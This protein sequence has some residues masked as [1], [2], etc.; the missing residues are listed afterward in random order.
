VRPEFEKLGKN[1][2]GAVDLFIYALSGAH[3][4]GTIPLGIALKAH[5][6]VNFSGG[7]R[8]D[9]SG[10]WWFGFDCGHAGDFSPGLHALLKRM[11]IK[12]STTRA[13]A[14]HDKH[15][16]LGA[17]TP[18]G[19]PVTYRTVEYVKG[20]CTA[21]ALQLAELEKFVIAPPL[22]LVREKKP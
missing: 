5:G 14:E 3:E 17:P 15:V 2:Y 4:H 22:N 6:G 18:W 21:L 7:L 13:F 10:R 20:E 1:D 9:T 11:H 8:D 16:G 12:D 19:D